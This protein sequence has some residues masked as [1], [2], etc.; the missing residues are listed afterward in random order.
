M[1]PLEL[2]VH[3]D[4]EIVI[5]AELAQLPLSLAELG[6]VFVIMSLQSPLVANQGMD[7]KLSSDIDFI[8]A[9]RGLKDKGVLRAEQ[10]GHRVTLTLDFKKMQEDLENG[11]QTEG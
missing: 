9:V 4:N 2:R 3:D 1:R 7:K 6:A 8:K 5:P 11:S 10:E